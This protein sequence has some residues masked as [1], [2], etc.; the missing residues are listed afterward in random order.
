MLIFLFISF[1]YDV[2]VNTDLV[3]SKDKRRREPTE[4]Q[5]E[6]VPRRRSSF[7]RQPLGLPAEPRASLLSVDEFFTTFLDDNAPRS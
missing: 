4:R 2:R 6:P 5:H 7:R 3:A 1:T